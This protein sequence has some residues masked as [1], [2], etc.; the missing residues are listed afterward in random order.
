[1]IV[2]M[3]LVFFIFLTGAP[4]R[5]PAPGPRS[6]VSTARGHGERRPCHGIRIVSRSSIQAAVTKAPPGKTFCLAPGIY[7][8]SS[9]IALKSHDTF[10]GT[11][12][13]R[14]GVTVKTDSAGV[15]FE[16]DQTIGVKFVHFA[17]TGAINACPGSNCGETGTA[18]SLGTG[19][20]LR[21]MHLY[22]NGLNG[23]GGGSMVVIDSEIDHNGAEAN[24]GVSAG[25]K[26]VNPITVRNSYIHDNEGAGV[27]CDIQCR[28]YTVV[29]SRVIRN[30]G[31]G[32][33][34]EISQGPAILANNIVKKNN[35]A[36]VDDTGGISI[37]N[38]KNASVYGNLL[39]NN[40]GFGI[41]AREDSRAG[42]CGI[43]D[44]DCGYMLSD[45]S[46]HDNLLRGD[47]LIGC[48]MHGVECMHNR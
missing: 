16:A 15:I 47:A 41:A 31:S 35:T 8:V 1:V 34:M 30:S 22:S 24:D 2:M 9:P 27:W 45:V 33:F 48:H 11:A 18:I 13:S 4:R 5:T 17:V 20:T 25:V 44:E 21:D 19:V 26:S 36:D 28:A 6:T 46:I 14:D 40:I 43:P 39:G 37:T 3:V 38:S 12:P 29:N 32:I 42:N 23:I 10:I 7:E